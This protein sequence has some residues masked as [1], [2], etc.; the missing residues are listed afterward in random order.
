MTSE[1]KLEVISSDQVAMG[2]FR[3]VFQSPE[4]AYESKPG[5]FL[6]VDCNIG[7]NSNQSGTL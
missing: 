2:L 3:I 6:M 5:Q 4:L 7:Q 1:H